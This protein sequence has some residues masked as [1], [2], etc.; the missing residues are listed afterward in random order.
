MLDP[1][2]ENFSKWQ[3]LRST[4]FGKSF[5]EKSLIKYIIQV[6]KLKHSGTHIHTH[7]QYG[8]H[9]WW[10]LNEIQISRASSSSSLHI[11]SHLI[12]PYRQ[13]CIPEWGMFL[14]FEYWCNQCKRVGKSTLKSWVNFRFLHYKPTPVFHLAESLFIKI[15][16]T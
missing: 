5:F 1:I 4:K 8:G 6:N 7:T 9:I 13:I 2:L 14:V 11:N 10:P 16:I 15:S 3:L 12:S